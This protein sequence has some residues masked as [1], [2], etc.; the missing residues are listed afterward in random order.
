MACAT[1]IRSASHGSVFDA[2]FPCE[3]GDRVT[4]IVPIQ[5]DSGGGLSEPR[6]CRNDSEKSAS[7][8]EKLHDQREPSLATE[9]LQDFVGQGLEERIR[10]HELA[11]GC[12]DPRLKLKRPARSPR[13]ACASWMLTRFTTIF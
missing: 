8:N 6:G 3:S 9:G 5:K 7:F 1:R 11:P 12:A 10:N 4:L 2:D 13:L